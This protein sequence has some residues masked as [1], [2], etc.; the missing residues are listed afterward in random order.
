V[1]YQVP[2]TPEEQVDRVVKQ[3]N[4]DRA[5]AFVLLLLC[6]LTRFV[7]YHQI[8]CK[9]KMPDTHYVG[10]KF[11]RCIGINCDLLIKELALS[12]EVNDI[13]RSLTPT[14]TTCDLGAEISSTVLGVPSELNLSSL[15]PGCGLFDKRNPGMPAK[16]GVQ[17]Y[18]PH[19]LVMSIMDGRTYSS[20]SGKRD[21]WLAETPGG[22]MAR[23]RRILDGWGISTAQSFIPYTILGLQDT[24]QICP[25]YIEN[26]YHRLLAFCAAPV[27][28]ECGTSVDLVWT[29]PFWLTSLTVESNVCNT[30]IIDLYSDVGFTIM[31][32]SE[33][34]PHDLPRLFL[35]VC[36]FLCLGKQVFQIPSATQ[37]HKLYYH[38]RLQFDLAV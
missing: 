19:D 16:G 26:N 25:S 20:S 1:N 9:A 12:A 32:V 35:A 2:P 21:Q 11:H 5:V 7:G 15:N 31:A 30:H 34:K 10:S 8:A 13:Y 3:V 27:L 17:T 23:V 24:E 28:E 14:K 36:L 38:V 37:L 6:I 29:N 33:C 22:R 4:S 18:T